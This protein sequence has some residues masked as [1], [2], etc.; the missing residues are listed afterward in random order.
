[1]DYKTMIKK[2]IMRPLKKASEW[3]VAQYNKRR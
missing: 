1:M 2:W 3:V